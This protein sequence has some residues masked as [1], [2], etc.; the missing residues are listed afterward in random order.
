VRP[1]L[2]K[3]IQSCHFIL[4]SRLK[5]LR[6]IFCKLRT[7]L[8]HPQALLWPTR[9]G[10]PQLGANNLDLAGVDGGLALMMPPASPMSCGALLVL[11]DN[12]DAFSTMTLPLS[13]KQLMT[14]PCLPLVFTAE[15]NDGVTGFNMNFTHSQD[16]SN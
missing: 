12:V 6:R 3:I 2:L 16:T 13:G 10:L 14:L 11:R 8:C 7:L 15:D 5:R 4:L 1:L 9:V